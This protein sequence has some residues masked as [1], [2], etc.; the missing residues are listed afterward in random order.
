MPIYEY[1]CEECHAHAELLVMSQQQPVCPKCGSTRLH[2][3]FSTFA[4]HGDARRSSAPAARPHAH[5]AGC[6]CCHAPG[7]ACGLN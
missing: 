1:T 7:G 4:A 5:G 3:E 2:K 6:G